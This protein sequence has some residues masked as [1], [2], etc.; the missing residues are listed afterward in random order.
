LAQFQ[1]LNTAS[2]ITLFTKPTDEPPSNS[3]GTILYQ[4]INYNDTTKCPTNITNP[5][6]GTFPKASMQSGQYY[7]LF[8]T[9]MLTADN[10][11]KLAGDTRSIQFGPEGS[12]FAVLFSENNF[13]GSTCEV[14]NHNDPD[15]TDNPIGQCPGKGEPVQRQVYGGYSVQTVTERG[16]GNCL[17]SMTVIKGKVL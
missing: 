11:N 15:L 16:P 13:T 9:S 14:V 1:N 3:K 12:F 17:N 5:G 4:C 10:G 2:S 8:I 7:S 6:T